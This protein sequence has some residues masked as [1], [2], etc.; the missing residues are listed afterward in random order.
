V[1][2]KPGSRI[3]TS[4]ADRILQWR[5][6]QLQTLVTAADPTVPASVITASY[7]GS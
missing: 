4:G 2:F 7:G 1:A 6:G 5:N 3:A